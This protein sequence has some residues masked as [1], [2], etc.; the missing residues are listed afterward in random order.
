MAVSFTHDGISPQRLGTNCRWPSSL[1]TM[2]I[3]VGAY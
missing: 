3:L 1:T 2:T